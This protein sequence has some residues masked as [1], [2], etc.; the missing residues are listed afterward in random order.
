M[1]DV[2]I[3]CDP[4][5]FVRDPSIMENNFKTSMNSIISEDDTFTDNSKYSINIKIL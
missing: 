5:L 4:I 2:F 1:L 3:E